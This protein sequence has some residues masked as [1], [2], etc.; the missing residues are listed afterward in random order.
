MQQ[1][2]TGSRHVFRFDNVVEPEVCK[3]LSDLIISAKG[4]E[5]RPNDE[6]MPWVDGDTLVWH[7]LQDKHLLRKVIEHR[8][9]VAGLVKECFHQVVFPEYTTIVLWKKGKSHPRH[10]DNGYPSDN[11][12]LKNR[13]FTSITYLNE[14]YEGGETFIQTEHGNDYISVPKTGSTVI[15]PSDETAEHGV[16]KVTDGMRVTLPIWFC[17]KLVDSEDKFLPGIL[18]RLSQ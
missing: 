2:D 4:S 8:A 14:G 5:Q 12:I 18:Q 17:A 1:V 13:I 9:C 11:G 15:F 6:Q 16:N 3:A 10:K 7:E